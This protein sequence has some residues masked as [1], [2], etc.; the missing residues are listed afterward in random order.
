MVQ[1]VSDAVWNVL[2]GAALSSGQIVTVGAC[3][4]AGG[5]KEQTVV[6]SSDW[7]ADSVVWN[8]SNKT[9][10]TSVSVSDINVTKRNVLRIADAKKL[11]KAGSA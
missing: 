11:V 8:I 10:T 5:V 2:W 4:T 6:V 9:I 7:N 1:K 3:P